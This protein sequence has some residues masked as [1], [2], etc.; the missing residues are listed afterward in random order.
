MILK[1]FPFIRSRVFG[2]LL[3]AFDFLNENG[4]KFVEK[5]KQYQENCQNADAG[6]M[7]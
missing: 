2:E 4:Q 6:F 3:V 1:T 5:R 7:I